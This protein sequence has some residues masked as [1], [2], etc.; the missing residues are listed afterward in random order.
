MKPLYSVEAE[1]DGNWT[2]IFSSHH[3]RWVKDAYATYRRIA[4][5]PVR[6]VKRKE[7]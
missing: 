6:F 1:I 2:P 7:D 4:P 5:W 3:R